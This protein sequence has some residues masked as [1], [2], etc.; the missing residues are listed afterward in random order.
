M[1][2]RT[3]LV[4]FVLLVCFA[5]YLSAAAGQEATPELQHQQEFAQLKEQVAA[6]RMVEARLQATIQK[7]TEDQRE[8]Q[9][10]INGDNPNVDATELLRQQRAKFSELRQ[11]RGILRESRTELRQLLRLIDAALAD[12]NSNEAIDAINWVLRNSAKT[13]E[14][15]DQSMPTR[16]FVA[17]QRQA[18]N[19][20]ILELEVQYT[21][22]SEELKFHHAKLLNLEDMT[23]E[24]ERRQQEIEFLQAVLELIPAAAGTSRHEQA[25][26][27]GK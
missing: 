27:D 6:L 22:V 25:T 12:E 26:G 20:E 2:F 15:G 13:Q 17:T 23:R 14:Q 4:Y 7:A 10:R 9:W 18:V 19:T 1:I 3:T 5:G 16:D 11:Q 21:T 24:I 8:L